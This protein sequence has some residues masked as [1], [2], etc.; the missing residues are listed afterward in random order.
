MSAL[1]DSQKPPERLGRLLKRRRLRIVESSADS[2][3]SHRATTTAPSLHR[4]PENHHLESHDAV[5]SGLCSSPSSPAQASQ[6]GIWQEQ[7]GR[8]RQLRLEDC[9]AVCRSRRAAIHTSDAEILEM[10]QVLNASLP[11]GSASATGS[12]SKATGCSTGSPSSTELLAT[13]ARLSV[14]MRPMEGKRLI[15]SL[16][17]TGAGRTVNALSK[18]TDGEVAKFAFRLASSWREAVAAVKKHKKNEIPGVA[19]NASDHAGSKL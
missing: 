13:L 5:L 3:G 16:Q 10:C 9:R 15:C 17:H 6:Q 7:Q 8:T 1:A 2:D 4:E 14:S 18:H 11:E 12:S 19:R